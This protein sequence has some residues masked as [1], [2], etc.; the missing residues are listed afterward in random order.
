MKLCKL[1]DTLFLKNSD[2]IQKRC[3]PFNGDSITACG[4]WCVLFEA[5]TTSTSNVFQITLHC[6][7][8]QFRVYLEK[9][10]IITPPTNG[11]QFIV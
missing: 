4:D 8:R 3:C 11:T 9:D 7:D 2:G 1:K 6:C 10:P 5:E